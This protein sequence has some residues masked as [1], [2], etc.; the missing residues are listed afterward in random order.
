MAKTNALKC[1]A[2]DAVPE[3]ISGGD[4]GNVA[5]QASL[6][7]EMKITGENAVP[8]V[9]HKS[10]TNSCHMPSN[11]FQSREGLTACACRR[12]ETEG[13][14]LCRQDACRMRAGRFSLAGPARRMHCL[15]QVC[16]ARLRRLALPVVRT[17]RRTWA[18]WAN[19]VSLHRPTGEMP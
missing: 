12:I 1:G 15:V 2:A 16:P 5:P 7:G 10:I 19:S 6:R 9:P 11:M 8:Q 17:A 14:H 4:T 13:A 18:C 3:G